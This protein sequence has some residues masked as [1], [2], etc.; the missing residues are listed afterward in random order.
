VSGIIGKLSFDADETLARS[1]LERMLDASVSSVGQAPAL[2][3][4]YTAR[5][6]GLGWCAASTDSRAFGMNEQQTVRV[7]ADSRLSNAGELRDELTRGGHRFRHQG[8]EE[9]IAHAYERWGTRCFERLHG[10]FACALWDETNRRLVLARDHV[11]LRPLHFAL[12]HGHG[13]VFASDIRALFQ[14]PG[15]PRDWCPDGIDAYLALGYVPAPL[16]AYRR[17]SKLEPAHVLVV[18]GRRLHLEEFWDLPVPS[19]ATAPKDITWALKGALKASVRRELKDRKDAGLLYSGGIASCA[20]LAAAP[21]NAGLPITVD[22]DHD[23]NELTRS[24]AAAAHLGRVRELETIARPVP[25]LIDEVTATSGEPIADPSALSEFAIFRAASNRTSVALSAH[26]ASILWGG[27][28]GSRRERRAAAAHARRLWD[29][30]Q[31]RSIYTRGFAW[32]VRDANPFLRHVER[33]ASRPAAHPIDRAL[34][35]DAR[36]ILPDQTLAL[37]SHAAAAAGIELRFPFLDRQLVEL[38]SATPCSMKQHRRISM[39]ALRGLLEADLPPRLMPAARPDAASH[40][41]LPAALSV[42]VPRI[43]LAPR[44]DG[45]GIVSR[46]ALRSLWTEH[47]SARVDHSRRL[48]ALLMLEF[49]FREFIDGDAAAEPLEYAVLVKAA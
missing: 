27:R 18:E 39:F 5:G 14:D 24:D 4:V 41:W 31:R 6:I 10:P 1:V 2:S 22:L 28:A 3:G 29:D 15:V 8:D 26:G 47:L 19:A 17:I 13:V 48:W 12:L 40:P 11:G 16:T 30:Q 25:A 38:A 21:S 35:V 33:Y 46:P 45:R 37:A 23:P 32:Q 43:L 9:I 42:L 49:W 36:T 34:Y 20:M 44:F 7:A